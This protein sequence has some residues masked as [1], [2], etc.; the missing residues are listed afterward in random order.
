[1][2]RLF[3]AALILAAPWAVPW[4]AAQAQLAPETSARPPA[5]PQVEAEAAA[6]PAAFALATPADALG[7]R[8]A[9]AEAPE[10]PSEPAASPEVTRRTA[11]LPRVAP[12]ARIAPELRPELRPEPRPERLPVTL[13]VVEPVSEADAAAI[14]RAVALMRDDRW[15]EARAAAAPAGAV[16]ED[17]VIWHELRERRGAW[18]EVEAFL[19]RRAGWPGLDELRD[20]VEG[21]MPVGLPPERVLPFFAGRAP[22]TGVGAARLHDALLAVGEPEA[23]VAVLVEAWRTLPMSEAQ[24]DA[25]L[26]RAP[27]ALAAHHEA[28]L[29]MLLWSDPQAGALRAMDRVGDDWRALARARMAL[30]VDGSNVDALIEAVPA[31]L[32]DDAGLAYERFRWRL[33]RGRDE[34]AAELLLARSA[35][36]ETLGRPELWAEEREAWARERMRAGDAGAAYALAAG[37]HLSGGSMR[38]DLEWLAGYVALIQMGDAERALG[39]FDNGLASVWTPISLGRMHY[40]RGR[41]LEA[42]GREDEARAAYREGGL[43]QTSFYGQLAA[44]KGGVPTDPALLGAP[45]PGPMPEA[46]AGNSVLQ[47]AELLLAAEERHL[48]A[49]FLAHLALTENEASLPH[50]GAWAAARGDH[51][52]QVK[53]GK[54]AAERGVV[55]PEHYYP[56]HPLAQA[57]LPVHPALALSIARRESEFHPGVASHVGAQGLMQLMPATAREVAGAL[58][59]PYSHGRLT[60]DPA[61]NARL[62]SAYLQGLE[63]RFGRNVPMVAAGYNAGPGR[64]AR[65]AAER[66]DPRAPGTDA[67][68][69]IEHIP[70]EETRN[71]VM[72]VMESVPVYRMRLSGELEPF[73]LSEELKAR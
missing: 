57:E 47:A 9:A 52:L 42:L 40:W 20:E 18:E 69:W 61:Y 55:L 49:R 14:R 64:P 26:E 21:L 25:L 60:A 54:A 4:S 27:D 31:R 28:R 13:P 11:A 36:A 35:S 45:D 48:A 71:Y 37:N 72:R 23:A 50:L 1:M 3:S 66:G 22:A 56:L 7:L 17:L 29:D 5:R 39:H 62:G 41:A 43:W 38:A 65:W 59:L 33:G 34:S 8:A 44:E 70:F 24:E 30:R 15:A 6:P 10:L 32:Q 63:V 67:I 58:G 73:R 12:L 51:F 16:A 68:D 53:I 46:L 2:H 19:A